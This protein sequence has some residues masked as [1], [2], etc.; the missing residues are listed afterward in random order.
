MFHTNL[1]TKLNFLHGLIRNETMKATSRTNINQNQQKKINRTESVVSPQ[2]SWFLLCDN[3]TVL[4]FLQ[5]ALFV[6]YH[7]AY[8]I[9]IEYVYSVYLT[10]IYT[11]SFSVLYVWIWMC[12][13]IVKYSDSTRLG[14]GLRFT[15]HAIQFPLTN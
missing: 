5:N 6:H 12:S 10:N 14:K 3:S 2:K 9:L 1:C 13:S 15:K 8:I 4:L 11:R 7:R